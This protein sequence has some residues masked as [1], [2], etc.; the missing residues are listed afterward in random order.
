VRVLETLEI[1]PTF[2]DRHLSRNL[3]SRSRMN[4]Y[5]LG[6]SL[7][8]SCRSRRMIIK[9]FLRSESVRGIRLSVRSR[10]RT[11]TKCLINNI[12]IKNIRDGPFPFI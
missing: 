6:Y 9:V 8:C 3:S 2:D 1:I 4:I 7:D 10:S 11:R 12:L 5:S